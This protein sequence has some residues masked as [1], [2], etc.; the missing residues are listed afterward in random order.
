MVSAVAAIDEHGRIRSAN[1]AFFKI[2]TSASIG[3]SVFEKIGADDAMKMLDA[4]ST[5]PASKAAYR[6]RWVSSLKVTGATTRH[7]MSML[8][9]C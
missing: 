6:G 2:F 9:R 4:A 1:A 5:S 7:L 8:R 3:A